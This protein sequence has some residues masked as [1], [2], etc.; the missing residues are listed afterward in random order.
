MEKKAKPQQ[1]G[2]K[3]GGSKKSVPKK[4]NSLSPATIAIVIG[5]LLLGFIVYSAASTTSSG[6]PSGN[7]CAE[8]IAYLQAGVDRYQAAFGVY[9][10]ELSQLLETTAGQEPFV[11]TIDLVCPSSGRPYIIENGVVRDS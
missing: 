1:T 2:K 3:T 6:G 11:E 10:T 4:K 5:I 8:N 7:V 9:P